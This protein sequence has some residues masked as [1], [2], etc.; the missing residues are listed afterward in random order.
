MLLRYTAAVE[1]RSLDALKRVWPG[2]SGIPLQAM[3]SEFQN[4]SRIS[5][6]IIEPR[7]SLS[8]DTGTVNFIRRYDVV[9]VEGQPLHSESQAM[10]DVR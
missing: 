4:A 6:E 8:A 7:M 1:A 2:L 9:T 5:V 3:R 10:M